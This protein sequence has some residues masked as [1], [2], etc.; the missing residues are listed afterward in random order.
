M[1]TSLSVT[2]K[3][4]GELTRPTGLTKPGQGQ[5]TNV[6]TELRGNTKREC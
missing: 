5:G 4:G 3:H 1:W 6:L 2:L